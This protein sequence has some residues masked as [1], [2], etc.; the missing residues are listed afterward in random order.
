M[1]PLYMAENQCGFTMFFHN[2]NKWSEIGPPTLT[3]RY[4][5]IY[6]ILY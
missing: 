3:G 2:L 6:K 4:N 1:G 5:S